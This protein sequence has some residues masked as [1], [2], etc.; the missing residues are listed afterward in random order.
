MFLRFS[1]VMLV[2]QRLFPMFAEIVV[3][4]VATPT[5]EGSE[6]SAVILKKWRLTHFNSNLLNSQFIFR[7]CT[8]HI[9]YICIFRCICFM[10]TQYTSYI[11]ICINIDIMHPIVLAIR[12]RGATPPP[13]PD[14][15]R[16]SVR[17]T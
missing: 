1:M 3:H 11:H 6:A 17:F 12:V 5:V 2:Y 14:P 9:V 10:Y 8:I 4:Q 15:Y 13:A 16:C 7:S